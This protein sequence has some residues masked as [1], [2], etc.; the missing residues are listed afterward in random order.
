[1]GGSFVESTLADGGDVDRVLLGVKENDPERFAVEK[2]HLRAQLGDCRGL[3]MVSDSRSSRKTT[4]PIRN[5]LTS[6]R[7]L[8][9]ETK[10]RSS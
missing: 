2:T 9:R 4:A 1:M 5:E 3:S 6:R 8:E 10:G 7:A